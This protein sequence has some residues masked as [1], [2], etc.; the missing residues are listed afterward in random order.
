MI[1]N[2]TF[3]VPAGAGAY[4]PEVLYLNAD[5]DK[6]TMPDVVGRLSLLLVNLIATVAIEVD[7]LK[8]GGDPS[9]ATHWRT[10]MKSYNT[11]GLQ[12]LLEL[13]NWIGVRIRAKSGGT[14]GVQEIDV[15]WAKGP[16]G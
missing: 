1:A 12:A 4:A 16:T 13:G 10:A 2:L 5:N 9:N 6:R 3:T 7:L 11:A 15:A 14:A 8:P